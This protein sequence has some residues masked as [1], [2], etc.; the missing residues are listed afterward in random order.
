MYI[1]SL[2]FSN[3]RNLEDGSVL[4]EDGLNWFTGPNGQGKT[5]FLESVYFV[6]TSKSFRTTRT[7]DMVR[8]SKKLSFVKGELVR[9]S[10][11]TAKHGVLIQDGK[12]KR[13]LAE[14]PVN[15]LDFLKSGAVIA[16]TA[17]SK[18]LVEGTPEDRRRFMDRMVCYLDPEHVLLLG[19]YRKVMNQL[20]EVLHGS[21]NLKL[22]QSFKSISVGLAQEIVSRR[23]K[24]LEMIRE[25]TH[26]IYAELFSGEEEIFFDYKLKNCSSM[27]QLGQKMM[28]ISAQ[29]LLYRRMMI[30]PQLDDLEIRFE[31]R[32]AKRFASSGQVRSIVLS[33]KLAVRTLFQRRK[34]ELPILLLDDI[35]AELDPK[36]LDKLITFLN[37]GGQTLI[38]TSKCGIMSGREGN[39]FSVISG[40]INSGRIGECQQM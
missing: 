24:F 19:K 18:A 14:K 35:D 9:K 26:R 7:A 12:N 28:D 6:L 2:S 16:F 32:G 3:F 29:E 22:Y 40:H 33:L 27:A 30:G 38:T 10:G 23:M 37:E 36:R 13:L 21:Q 15:T 1:K 5:N 39:V 11:L 8:E 20:K 31:K 34:E 17:R 4:L 25:E